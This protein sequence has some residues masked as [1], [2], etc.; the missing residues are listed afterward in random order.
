MSEGIKPFSGYSATPRAESPRSLA[1]IA[2]DIA[3]NWPKVYFGAAPYLAA[4][5]QLDTLAGNYGSDDARGIVLY[6]LS[7]ATS[8][9]GEHARRIKAEL[10]RMLK[11]GA[12]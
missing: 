12:K 4:M 8:W 6:F 3:A 7:N 10:N 1:T 2:Q 5:R 11:G 9:R